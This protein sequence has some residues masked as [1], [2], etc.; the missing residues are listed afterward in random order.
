MPNKSHVVLHNTEH[1]TYS[2]IST[3]SSWYI[4]LMR[5]GKYAEVYEGTKKDCDDWVEEN[6]PAIEKE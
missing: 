5:S 3:N 4:T 1:N 2:T 6:H